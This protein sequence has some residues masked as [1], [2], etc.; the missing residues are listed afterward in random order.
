[1]SQLVEPS[2]FVK[3]L[4]DYRLTTA[5]ILY[6][7]PDHPNLLQTYIWQD[8]DLCPRYPVLRKF[9]DFWSKNLDGRLHSVKVSSCELMHVPQWRNAHDYLTLH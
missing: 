2:G 8:Y 6:H 1:M 5:H 3:Q 4:Q 9:L 7:M